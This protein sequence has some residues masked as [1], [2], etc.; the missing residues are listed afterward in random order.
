MC[1]IDCV[2]V[3]TANRDLETVVGHFGNDDL[4]NISQYSGCDDS[5]SCHKIQLLMWGSNTVG[6]S[7]LFY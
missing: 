4:C 3:L 6:T 1:R 5:D 7:P 2:L